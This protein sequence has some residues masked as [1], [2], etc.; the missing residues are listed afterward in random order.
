MPDLELHGALAGALAPDGPANSAAIL[1]AAQPPPQAPAVGPSA[2]ASSA[3]DEAPSGS[4]PGDAS[5]AVTE[6]ADRVASLEPR[7]ETK[8]ST[9]TRSD[10]DLVAPMYP[11]VLRG[12]APLAFAKENR[13][14]WEYKVVFR[15]M[16][17][18]I[19]IHHSGKPLELPQVTKKGPSM[20]LP[21][22]GDRIS[23]INGEALIGR[24]IDPMAKLLDVVK[25]APR[26]VTLSFRPES[27]PR[28]APGNVVA[29]KGA[30]DAQKPRKTKLKHETDKKENPRAKGAATVQRPGGVL[31]HVL[32][33][34]P[35]PRPRRCD[36]L[37]GDRVNWKH[38]DA[39]V[40]KG[41]A[42]RVVRIH[43]DGDVEVA[44]PRPSVASEAIYTFK[45]KELTLAP[46]SPLDAQTSPADVPDVVEEA[47]YEA[48]E[49]HRSSNGSS[50]FV[51]LH[52]ICKHLS[53]NHEG[54]VGDAKDLTRRVRALLRLGVARGELE[55]NE[56]KG[57]SFK[58]ARG[59]NLK[60]KK[61]RQQSRDCSSSTKVDGSTGHFY[62]GGTPRTQS[63]VA[64]SRGWKD[65]PKRRFVPHTPCSGTDRDEIDLALRHLVDQVCLRADLPEDACD[66]A[67]TL[68]LW[69]PLG[70]R[71]A[72]KAE[73]LFY[74]L[75]ALF[76]LRGNREVP[77][78]P[79][80]PM[81]SA[82][83]GF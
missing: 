23:S 60:S 12:L 56:S 70:E 83:A 43:A 2:R 47:A 55:S 4:L 7:L 17:L 31:K 1:A 18:G 75:L 69:A 33:S 28:G 57:G 65:L 64:P 6:S 41:Q 9:D 39:D 66:P 45:K 36:L 11:S 34:K 80:L 14:S 61:K 81:S 38:F 10:Q 13:H 59:F 27:F 40:P 3:S 48:I 44:F 74:S 52:R 71:G 50:V 21:R 25:S 78:L 42:G 68:P 76:R 26:P 20:A 46:P 19:R 73:V 62:G 35:T 8:V 53:N 15:T 30:V 63:V 24:G 58:F 79:V 82:G 22:E 49:A 29:A 77:P 67:P 72:S 5:P 16:K 37:V 32:L 51:S 54:C